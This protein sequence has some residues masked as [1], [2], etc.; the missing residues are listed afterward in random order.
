MPLGVDRDAAA[1]FQQHVGRGA[2]LD[3]RNLSTGVRSAE[4]RAL[5]VRQRIQQTLRFSDRQEI[6]HLS[7]AG[8]VAGV[9]L[10]AVRYFA[11]HCFAVEVDLDQRLR[12]QISRHEDFQSGSGDL[13][14]LDVMRRTDRSHWVKPF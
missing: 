10:F 4:G 3:L 6:L 9:Q 11:Q 8:M 2:R 7:D 13:D 12:Y 1:I 14:D 5:R